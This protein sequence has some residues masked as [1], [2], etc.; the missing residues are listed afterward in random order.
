VVLLVASITCS[1]TQPDVWQ[2]ILA[3]EFDQPGQVYLPTDYACP[4]AVIGGNT[5][6]SGSTVS[7]N[8][9]TTACARSASVRSPAQA[10]G[11]F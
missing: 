9:E 1:Q 11:G 10:A 5:F 7:R 4:A 8:R 3:T 6:K 2:G